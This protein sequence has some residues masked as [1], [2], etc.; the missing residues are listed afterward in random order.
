MFATGK[1]GDGQVRDAG[2]NSSYLNLDIA[3]FYW[4]E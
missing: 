2:Q 1:G 4:L 3:I